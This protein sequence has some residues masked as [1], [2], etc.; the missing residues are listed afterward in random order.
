[1]RD[2][3]EVNLTVLLTK[4]A[5]FLDPKKGGKIFVFSSTLNDIYKSANRLRNIVL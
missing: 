4:L 1:M 3:E 5:K 2:V